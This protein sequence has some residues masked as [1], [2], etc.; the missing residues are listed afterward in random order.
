MLRMKEIML[1]VAAYSVL[2]AAFSKT[3]ASIELVQNGKPAASIVIPAAPSAVENYAANELQYH[4]K[5]STGATLEIVKESTSVPAGSHV[6]LGDCNAARAA[7][8]D[9]S[10]LPANGYV[11]KTVGNDLY[12]VGK[13]GPGDPMLLDTKEGTLF[14]VYDVLENNMGIHWLWPGKLGEVI[15]ER[16]TI[17][18]PNINA[19]VEPLLY[20]KEWRTGLE[21]QIHYNEGFSS[22]VRYDDVNTTGFAS[23]EKY[24]RYIKD[25]AQWLKRQR[26]G[27]SEQP[28]YGHAFTKWWARFS[29][30]HPDYF[31]MLPDGTRCPDP[32]DGAKPDRVHMCVSNP[33]MWAQIVE[34]WKAIGAPACINVCE[35]DNLG[36]CVCPVCLAW[37]EPDPNNNVPFEQRFAVARKIYADPKT[38]VDDWVSKLGSLSDRYAKYAEA[39]QKGAAK[40]RPDVKVIMYAYNNY[41]KPPIKVKLNKK[42]FIGIVPPGLGPHNKGESELFQKDWGGWAATGCILFL[43]PNYTLQGHN[44]PVFYARTV[45]EDLKFGMHNSMKGVDFDS[46][47][48]Q[49]STQGPTLYM[50]AKMLNY[51]K[52]SVEGVLDEYCDAFGPAKDAVKE[53]FNYWESISSPYTLDTTKKMVAAKRKYGAGTWAGFHAIAPLIYTPEVMSKGFAILDKARKAAVGSKIASERVEWLTTGLK[54]ADL[55]VVAERAFEHAVDTGDSTEFKKAY[56]ALQNFR[57]QNTDEALSNFAGLAGIENDRWAKFIH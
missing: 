4:V 51:P 53:Y 44:F 3:C 18:I 45:G 34:D 28:E 13:D 14:G 39:V 33:A 38:D 1:T 20:F 31:N 27:R 7:G 30:T 16:K 56:Q 29:K 23:K 42:V 55:V 41:R 40:I 6:Y 37:D 25:E 47:T 2:A 10:R 9:P 8:A 26:F 57:S 5:A 11:I 36:G 50:I 19:S 46:L 22:E 12:I 21:N 32:K 35:N 43:R 52:A 17:D 15:P 48:G 24:D 49:F 54:G